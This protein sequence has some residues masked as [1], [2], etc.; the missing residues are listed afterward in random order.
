[1]NPYMEENATLLSRQGTLAEK[2][3][4]QK[5]DLTEELQYS[6]FDITPPDIN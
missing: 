1:M 5:K 6:N 2:S 3:K 4:K